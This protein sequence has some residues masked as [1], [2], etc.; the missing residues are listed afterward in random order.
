MLETAGADDHVADIE[1]MIRTVKER[2]RATYSTLPFKCIPSV[3]ISHMV[4][5]AVFWLNAF[6]HDNGISRMHSPRYIMTGVQLDYNKHARLEFGEYVQSHEKHDSS[7]SERTIGAI[8]LGPTGNQQGSHWFLNLSTGKRM[9]RTR[10]TRLPMP[11]DA[12]D[13][14]N[15]LGR[16]QG[17]PTRM[18]FANRQGRELEDASPNSTRIQMTTTRVL[19]PTIHQMTMTGWPMTRTTTMLTNPAT[20]RAMMSPCPPSPATEDIIALM[21]PGASQQSQEWTNQKS[22]E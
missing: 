20:M 16:H 13:R 15:H 5:N 18:T 17:M 22:Q 3:M 12:I 21:R 7:M 4:R 14:V 2:C 1:R 19:S 8:N 10:W 11:Q 9:S 6:P